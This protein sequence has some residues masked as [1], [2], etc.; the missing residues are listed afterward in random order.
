[1]PSVFIVWGTE[2]VKAADEGEWKKMENM[3]SEYRFKT[4]L[5]IVCFLQGIEEAIGWMDY[6]VLDKHL[7][8]TARKAREVKRRAK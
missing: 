7:V 8:E 6:L 1:M 3:P 5:E 4:R 2:D